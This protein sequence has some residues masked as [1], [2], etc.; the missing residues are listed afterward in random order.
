M[1]VSEVMNPNVITITS[2]ATVRDCV[3]VL[4]ENKISG[5]PVVDGDKLVGIITER[6]ILKLLKIPEHGGYWLPSPLEVIE[7]PIRDVIEWLE[8]R[9]SITED[10]GNWSVERAMTKPVHTVN[11]NADIEEASEHM[12]RHGINRLPVVDATGRLMGIVTR[13]DIVKGIAGIS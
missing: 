10:V 1:K 5:A 13:G 7:V 3:K 8:L 6:D 4:R 11:V 9:S 12:V 2:D